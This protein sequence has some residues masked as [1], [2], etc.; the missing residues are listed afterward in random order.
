MLNICSLFQKFFG[1]IK[2][3]QKKTYRTCM[4]IVSGVMLVSIIC[5][6]AKDFGGSGKNKALAVVVKASIDIE[7]ET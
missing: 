2:N 7:A 3:V 5:L 4:V 6:T 1:F